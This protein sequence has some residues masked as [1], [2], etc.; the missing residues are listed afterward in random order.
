MRLNLAGNLPPHLTLAQVKLENS[1]KIMNLVEAGP[2]VGVAA[3]SQIAARKAASA[4][5]TTPTRM[6]T[7]V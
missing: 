7:V 5:E 3:L 2:P 6:R 4:R 1:M